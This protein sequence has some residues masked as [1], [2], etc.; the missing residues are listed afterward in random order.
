MEEWKTYKIGE[1]CESISDTYKGKAPNV[2]LVNTSDVYDGVCLNHTYVPNKDLKGQFKKIFKRNDILYSEIRPANRR[3][4]FVDFAPENYIASTKL[5]V[6]RCSKLVRPRYLYHYL[7]RQEMLD[8]L[9][10]LAE[11]RSGTFPQITF[12][13]LALFEI[14][15]PSLTTQ[16]KIVAAIDCFDDKIALNN[17][18]NHNLEEQA[19][20]LYKSWFV[21]F[22][23]FKDGKFID[24]ELGM[25]PDG[26]HVKRVGDL[27]LFIADYVANG[28]FASL[29][30]NVRL[31]ESEQYAVFIRNTDLKAGVFPVFVDTH[32][33]NFLSKTKLSGGEIIISNVGDVGSVHFC[34]VLNRPMTLGNNVIMIK[35]DERRY[36]SFLYLCFKYFSGHHSIDGITGGSAMPKFN[37][38]D[39]KGIKIIVPPQDIMSR[40]DAIASLL[41]QDIDHNKREC[42]KLSVQRNTLLPALMS[43]QLIC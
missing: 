7:K 42:E 5:M 12:S 23:P 8:E 38:T 21:D 13:E 19:Q 26:W 24:S 28:S 18:I 40:F 36:Y 37:K 35:A 34:P 2:V 10:A 30:E 15:L 33:Y 39:F 14:S 16:D 1:I 20:A 25:I 29:K 22:E 32:S 11:S 4:A 31:Y 41:F 6:I 27:P 9:Q 43:G 17:R 3:F